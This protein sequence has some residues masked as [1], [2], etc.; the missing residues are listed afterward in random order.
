[1]GQLTSRE[2]S[3]QQYRQA[4]IRRYQ[5]LPEVR[6]IHKS[7]KIPKVIQKQT[8]QT[9]IQKESAD[10][11]QTNRVKYSKAG[12]HEFVSERKKVVVKKL[13]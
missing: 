2:E 4:L 8:A 12:E 7:R 9:L 1:L 5:H 10:R 6:R 3:A 13:E 11:K